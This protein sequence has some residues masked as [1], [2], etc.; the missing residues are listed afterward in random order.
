GP[1]CDADELPWGGGGVIAII[2]AHYVAMDTADPADNIDAASARFVPT[3]LEASKQSKG[4]SDHSENARRCETADAI[5]CRSGRDAPPLV[6]DFAPACITSLQ[7]IPLRA[8]KASGSPTFRTGL[9][10]PGRG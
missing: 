3:I 6:P 4:A 9:D 5:A 8:L 1:Q 10:A 2:A 7:Q